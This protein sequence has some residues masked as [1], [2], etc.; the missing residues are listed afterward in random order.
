MTEN[1]I[2]ELAAELVG[3]IATQ[4][5][6]DFERDATRQHPVVMPRLLTAK[7]SAEYIG[8]S[9]QAV[10]HLL[11]QREIPVVRNGRCVRVDRKDLDRW[12][13]NSKS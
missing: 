10:R 3:R 4:V 2:A 11:F 7:Q 12:I 6:S 9:E 1:A 13:E 8:R 5:K